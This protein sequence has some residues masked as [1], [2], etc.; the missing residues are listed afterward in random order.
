VTD[1]KNCAGG[2]TESARPAADIDAHPRKAVVTGFVAHIDN[3]PEGLTELLS[4]PFRVVARDQLRGHVIARNPRPLHAGIRAHGEGNVQLT[5]PLPLWLAAEDLAYGGMGREYGERRDMFLRHVKRLE[6]LSKTATPVI[7]FM[8]AHPI[9]IITVANQ[10]RSIPTILE[11]VEKLPRAR[12]TI[13]AHT[14]ATVENLIG[15]LHSAGLGRQLQRIDNGWPRVVIGT[16]LRT[17]IGIEDVDLVIFAGVDSMR[18]NSSWLPYEKAARARRFLITPADSLRGWDRAK[19]QSMC[20]F[21]ELQLL[22]DGQSVRDT[23][24]AWLEHR[25]HQVHLDRQRTHA[26][27]RELVWRAAPR[28]RR[29]GRLCRELAGEL[30]SDEFQELVA[31]APSVPTTRRVILLVDSVEHAA[32]LARR[33]NWPVAMGDEF[34]SANEAIRHQLVVRRASIYG[35]DRGR[36]ITAAAARQIDWSCVDV[37]VRADAGADL[38]PIPTHS[39]TAPLLVIDVDDRRNHALSRLATL[40]H[41]AYQ[42]AG[43]YAPDADP[44]L[45]RLRQFQREIAP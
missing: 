9:G 24:I 12:I 31:I 1:P 22:S 28:N 16:A 40:R 10:E 23:R 33:T 35:N 19:A 34:D 32:A 42:Q 25:A 17:D 18:T 43:W 15:A 39:A 36:V 2:I 5:C 29:I 8:A 27:L 6:T 30:P 20:G 4:A 44:V 7:A 45:E 41:Q 13:V 14:N 26:L 21:A 38:P 11:V 37:V 3:P